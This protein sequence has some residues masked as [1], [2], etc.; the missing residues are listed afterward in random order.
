MTKKIIG[1]IL[2]VLVWSRASFAIEQKLYK[3]AVI[4]PGVVQDR[5]YNKIGYDA[6]KHVENV[7][8]LETTYS[9][10]VDVQTAEEVIKTHISNGFNIIW[11]HGAQYS[12]LITEI[13]QN[14]PEVIFIIEGDDSP[15]NTYPNVIVLGFS[16]YYKGFYVL[17]AL[18]AKVSKTGHIGYIGGMELPYTYGEINAAWQAIHYYNPFAKLHYLYVGSFNEPLKTRLAAEALIAQSCDVLLSGV[19]LGNFGLFVA[20]KQAPHKVFFT[21]TCTDK[22]G[23]APEQYLC[24]DVINY[25]PPLE[26]ILADI[27]KKGI[28]SGYY[29]FGWGEGKA[30]YISFPIQNVSAELN[31]EI[32][33]IARNVATGRIVVDKI[34]DELRVKN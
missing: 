22:S 27:V 12:N 10:R 17:G 33:N 7:F 30:S 32:E 25:L 20:V 19:N 13:C 29:P 9:L 21:T 18:A 3:L 14:Y 5:D 16:E 28:R 4:F 26:T 1:V 8:G 15:E 23:Y 24:S 6:M 11:T 31:A 2:M 34:T